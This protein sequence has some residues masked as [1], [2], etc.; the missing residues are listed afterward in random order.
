MK[1]LRISSDLALP[2]DVV[3][4]RISILGRT[5]SG[6][7]HTAGVLVEEVMKAHQQAVVIDP[8]GDWWGLRSSADGKLAGLDIT[9][10]GGKHGDIPLE[11]TAGA[12]VADIVMNEGISVILDLSLFESKAAEVRF[13]EAFLD[14]LYRKNENP[15][16]LV[17]D[18]G[19]IFAPQKPE[20]NETTMLNRME[21]VC[22]RGGQRGIGVVLISQRS[23]SIHKGC[24]SQ[25][26]LL[27]AHQTT[28]PQDRKAIREWAEGKGTE[29][30][31]K[32]L[33]GRL[34]ALKTGMAVV[35]SPAW[36][37]LFKEIIVRKKETFDSGATPKVGVKRR[38]PKILA[39]VDME[40]I[41][42]YMS[43]TLE[44]MKSEDPKLLRDEIARLKT[45]LA[46][47]KTSKLAP[48][49]QAAPVKT[50]IRKV[51]VP[52]V[53]ESD[54][55]RIDAA[56]ARAEKLF[57]KSREA[58]KPIEQAVNGLRESVLQLRHAG[59][60]AKAQA[61]RQPVPRALTPTPPPRRSV[62]ATAA[63]ALD[64]SEKPGNGDLIA[65]ERKM[66]H[67]LA[68]IHPGVLTR[69]QLGRLSGYT[70][71]GGTFGQ[72]YGRLKRESYVQERTEIIDGRSCEVV[73]LT[74]QGIGMFPDGLPE[75]PTTPE[76]RIEFWRERLKGGEL[77]MFDYLVSIFPKAVTVE[78][79]GQA[80]GYTSEGGTFGQY[81]GT[82][83]RNRLAVAEDQ[84]Y[85][86]SPEL[87]EL[88]ASGR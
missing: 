6:K 5:R 25:T 4:Q 17:V 27:I 30:Q 31:Q 64:R 32:Q 49:V 79:L 9:I 52:A 38:A 80:T 60:E 57:E 72:Y 66:L 85:R 75:G 19:D 14:R 35:W 62:L 63:R 11:P 39:A 28:A 56:I 33:M 84:G 2:I 82:L 29:E 1:K 10:F 41:K 88:E 55:K 73:S 48:V 18:E 3:T 65:G 58:G 36:L 47:A 61:V 51:E 44:K 22:R 20:K 16:L 54:L 59:R 68:Q 15:I 50:E 81:L 34:A 13:M 46:R 86:A 42:K 7:S 45:E 23:A 21:T 26:E 87:F 70:P 12:L 67:V 43:E 78:E 74:E 76:E 69:A 24:L 71:S 40:R 53:K 37:D 8:K 83:R 77:K